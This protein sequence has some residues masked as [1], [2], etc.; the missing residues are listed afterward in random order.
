MSAEFARL[1]LAITLLQVSELLLRWHTASLDACA[2]E[3]APHD[4]SIM[5]SVSQRVQ[6]GV[7][8]LSCQPVSRCSYPVSRF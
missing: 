1:L 7:C 3:R 8:T 4:W 5:L 6:P 2:G